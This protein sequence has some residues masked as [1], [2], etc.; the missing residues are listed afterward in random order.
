[1]SFARPIHHHEKAEGHTSWFGISGVDGGCQKRLA[2]VAFVVKENGSDTLQG[3]MHW[4]IGVV[5]ALNKYCIGSSF[6]SNLSR[7]NTSSSSGYQGNV[8]CCDGFSPP[9]QP[10]QYPR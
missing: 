6:R 3:M 1:M 2:T 9:L 4:R 10:L 7:I 5:A 8:Q